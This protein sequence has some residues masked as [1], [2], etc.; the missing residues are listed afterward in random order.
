M[1]AADFLSDDGDRVSKG[2]LVVIPIRLLNRSTEVWGEDAN[3]FRYA[4]VWPFIVLYVLTVGVLNHR[5]E[6][7]DDVPDAANGLPSVYGH[8]MTFIAGAHA[9]IGYRFSV[10]ECVYHIIIPLS[11]AKPCRGAPRIV[12][13]L[14]NYFRRIKALLFTL[15]RTFEFELALEPEDI[16][17]KT[18][19]VGRPIIASNPS[20]GPQLP[21]LIRLANTD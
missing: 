3:E 1:G 12:G 14:T 21:L 17:R 8:L 4:Q 19:I 11:L 5:P 9:C 6:R 7:W 16:V 15:V 18:G 2:D 10:T 20:A 13:L